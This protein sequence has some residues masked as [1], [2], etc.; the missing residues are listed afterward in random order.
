MSSI[1]ANFL[2]CTNCFIIS[3]LFCVINAHFIKEFYNYTTKNICIVR[4]LAKW[5]RIWGN[6]SWVCHMLNTI[7]I[8]CCSLQKLSTLYLIQLKSTY[9]HLLLHWSENDCLGFCPVG[10]WMDSQNRM[11]MSKVCNEKRF[12]LC[13]EKTYSHYQQNNHNSRYCKNL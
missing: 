4:Y 1:F 5:G 3:Y 6:L 11:L 12:Q 7:K 9:C 2:S 13:S 8:A 10:L